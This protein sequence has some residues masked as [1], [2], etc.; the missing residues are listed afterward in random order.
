MRQNL[1]PDFSGSLRHDTRNNTKRGGGAAINGSPDRMNCQF[2]LMRGSLCD[3]DHC[4]R[5]PA[6]GSLPSRLLFMLEAVGLAKGR[7]HH[8][9]EL[10]E[11]R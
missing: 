9:V 4:A 10:G 11:I 3:E 6:E 5:L 2:S 1:P 8:D 7:S